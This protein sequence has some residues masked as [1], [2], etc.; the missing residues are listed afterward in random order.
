MKKQLM[1]LMFLLNALTMTTQAQDTVLRSPIHG[2]LDSLHS[3]ALNQERLFQ[4]FLPYDYKPEDNKKYDVLYVLD[5]GNW[6]TG[7]ITQVQRFVQDQGYMPQTI[8]VSVMGIDRNVE[9]TPTHL[10]DWKGSGGAPQFLAY[11]KNELIPY[12]NHHYPANGEN[13]LWGHSLSAMFAVYAMLTEPSV[14]KSYIAVDPSIWWDHTLVAK[15][16]AAKLKDLP[17]GNVTL[18][19]AGRA[20]ESMHEMKTD[21]LETILKQD[22]PAGLKWKVHPYERE[23]HSSVRFKASY[24]GLKFT[25]EGLTPTVLFHPMNG[26]VQKGKPVKLYIDGDTTGVHF[27]L[28]S[29]LPTANSPVV[30]Q[31]LTVSGPATVIYRAISN[32]PNYDKTFTGRFKDEKP[33]LPAKSIKNWQCGG[34]NYA[35]YE[36]DWKAWPDLKTIKSVK[37]GITDKS[38]DQDKLPRKTH[39]A[40]IVDG[41]FEAKEDGYYIFFFN[42]DKGSKLYLA[43][44]ELIVWDGDYNKP[45]YSYIMPLTKGLYPFRIEYLHQREDFK[46]AWG[47]VPPSKIA[48]MDAGPI[49]FELEFHRK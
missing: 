11:I 9:L 29:S 6:N 1:V 40:L 2:K 26:I 27:T 3:S 4:V 16:A 18:Y 45:T 30:T 36:G 17:L 23:T 21:T 32:R 49:P 13:T 20:G 24:D 48:H 35:Y 42:A 33:P 8:I 25:Y 28:D 5:G 37:T 39:F 10:A 15:M 41:M 46:L 12:I 47:Y 43:N 38:F 7:L 22:A 14:F 19:I 31:P 34:L 44:K